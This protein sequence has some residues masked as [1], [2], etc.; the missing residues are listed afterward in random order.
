MA[1]GLRKVEAENPLPSWLDGMVASITS[2]C[3]SRP[4]MIRLPYTS[5]PIYVAATQKEAAKLRRQGYQRVWTEAKARQ[6]FDV[7]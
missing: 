1:N 6:W 3:E 4:L 7:C 2:T 5:E